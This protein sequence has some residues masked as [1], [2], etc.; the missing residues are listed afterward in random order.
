M[1]VC[2]LEWGFYRE[3][4][5][6]SASLGHLMTAAGLELARLWS[7]DL[8][9]RC[10][11]HLVCCW[12]K[13]IHVVILYSTEPKSFHGTASLDSLVV[14]DIEPRRL[15]GL[16]DHMKGRVWEPFNPRIHITCMQAHQWDENENKNIP[17]SFSVLHDGKNHKSLKWQ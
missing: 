11:Q 7:L 9:Q 12:L 17:Q 13:T 1:C 4:D 6:K 8:L 14:Y 3:S 10:S 5:T 16:G 15:V 2:V